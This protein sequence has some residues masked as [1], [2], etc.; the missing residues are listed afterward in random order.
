MA[1]IL[2]FT[3][4]PEL[5]NYN[6]YIISNHY[7]SGSGQLC[8]QKECSV[9]DIQGILGEASPAKAEWSQDL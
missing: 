5:F 4:K 9:L 1:G 8:G 7:F 3:T 6:N 2:R